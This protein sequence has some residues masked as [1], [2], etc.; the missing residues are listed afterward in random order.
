MSVAVATP[1]FNGSEMPFGNT[2]HPLD[3][4]SV[5]EILRACELLKAIKKLGRGTAL[6]DGPSARTT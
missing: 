2:A 1:A 6:R 5:A 4:L 3:P